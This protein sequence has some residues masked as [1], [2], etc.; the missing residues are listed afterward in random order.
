MSQ[1]DDI[2]KFAREMQEQVL[3]QAR[4]IYSEAVIDRWQNPK[5]FKTLEKPDG[6]ATLQGSCGDTMEMSLKVQSDKIIE[7][8]FQTDGC[9]TTFACGSVA[10]ELAGGKS[11]V[12]ALAHVS[13]DEIL[14]VLGGLPEADEHCAQLA[15]ETMRRALADYIYQKKTPWKKQYRKT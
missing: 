10:T 3:Q 7:C 13:A 15:A 11:V 2:E 5:N 12:Q 14:K 9:G 8:G 6:H 4:Q 1:E